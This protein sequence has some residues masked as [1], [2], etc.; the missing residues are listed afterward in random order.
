MS[1][2][3]GEGILV[4]ASQTTASPTTVMHELFHE[5]GLQHEMSHPDLYCLLLLLANADGFWKVYPNM[6]EPGR[7]T[8][9][10]VLSDTDYSEL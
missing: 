5:L 1:A 6:A 2:G 3:G 4:E 10:Y 8:V 9:P 7:W